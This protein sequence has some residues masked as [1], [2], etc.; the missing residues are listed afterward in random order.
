MQRVRPR[1]LCPRADVQFRL[2]RPD[3]PEFLRLHADAE[4]AL[5]MK[6]HD[7]VPV[8]VAELVVAEPQPDVLGLHHDEIRLHKSAYRLHLLQRLHDDPAA[9]Q[10]GEF[11][12]RVFVLLPFAHTLLR[13][14]RERLRSRLHHGLVHRL[15]A[16]L[17]EHPLQNG[18]VA[19]VVFQ[20]AG[21][22]RDLCAMLIGGG[23]FVVAHASGS[24][25]DF[26]RGPCGDEALI[27]R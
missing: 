27:D 2:P 3:R 13:K 20:L 21:I 17:F 14:A 18:G 24:S 11:L 23:A 9:A 6:L 16:R 7:V 25:G 12:R 5:R 8:A 10:V 22:G 26:R 1:M 15:L 19:C 4:R